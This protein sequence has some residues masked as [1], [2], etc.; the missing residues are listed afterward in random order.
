[1]EI[2]NK[3]SEDFLEYANAVITSRAIPKVQDNLKPVHRRVLYSMAIKKLWS[4]KSMLKCANVV[5]QVMVYH[6]HGDSAIYDSLIRLSQDWKM[7]YP[8]VEVGGNNGS[9]LGDP[10]AAS[11][12][13]ECRLSKIGELMLE[14]LSPTVVPFK[15]NYD[16]TTTEPTMLPSKF[17]N[18][19]CNGN[20]G[21]A[22][23]L[24]S[25]LVPHNLTE[26]VSAILAYIN[27]NKIGI[28]EL[29]EYIP[30]PDFPTGGVIIDSEKLVDIYTFGSGAI[31]L[32][33]KYE[34]EKIGTKQAIHFT[35][36]PYLIDVEEGVVKKIKKLVNEDGFDLIEGYEN[37]TN[38]NGISLRV[39]LKKGA[40]VYKVLDALWKNT[41]LQTSQRISN[42]VIYNGVPRVLNLKEMIVHYINYRHE[43]I[44]NIAK[45]ELIKVKNKIIVSQ[46]LIKA[47]KVIDDIIKIIRASNDKASA[48]LS[49]IKKYGFIEMQ[50][51]AILDMK[52]SKLSKLD[53]EEI[54]A[55]LLLLQKKEKEL[56]KIT[57][58][59]KYRNE[60]I[61]KELNQMKAD[62]GD[63]RRTKLSNTSIAVTK[64]ATEPVNMI[65]FENGKVFTSQ[66][67]ISKMP[68]GTRSSVLNDAA[69]RS[70]VHAK[71]IDI[72]S[73]FSSDGV[74]TKHKILNL[75]VDELE[76][77][78]STIDVVAAFDIENSK[79]EMVV[80][81]T[82]EGTV[83]MTT[84]D[85]Y[86]KVK[87]T[88][89]AIKLREGDR[90]IYV[91]LVNK[92]DVLYILGE[93]GKLV[94]FSISDITSTSRLTIGTKG[95]NDKAI[96]ALA[97]G[98][99]NKIFSINNSNQAKL[100]N[101]D[102]FN[103]TAKGSNGQVITENTTVILDGDKDYILIYDNKKNSLV[104]IKNLAVKSKSSIGAKIINGDI[105]SI[106]N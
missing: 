32:Q 67:D 28:E 18:I 103:L 85:E 68:F 74:I 7:R 49:I 102:D 71:P 24:S 73:T 91:G 93:K 53:N 99:N 96:C 16:E 95:I 51:E 47:I 17:P 89:K 90:L 4:N 62:F 10:A 100:T 14:D 80:F 42:T 39:F 1:M 92:N 9:V 11:R 64:L 101:A 20:A 5:G 50:A 98:P 40:N 25:S 105:I 56:V 63:A 87:T 70:I 82:Q 33:A 76:T 104:S 12:Y 58:N 38:R 59:E 75:T 31:T 79:K 72:L 19:I 94:K 2:N 27:N 13:T 34:I 60:I 86:S 41:R 29:M 55:D 37:N 52:L 81:V 43:I 44:T 3:I 77:L 6:P 45:E 66:N 83:K 57:T 23:G 21:I 8:L 78:D 97:C 69:I 65:I 106:V 54:E 84:I 88:T 36:I 61:I 35:E 22:V 48:K 26:A 15:S 30:G 46:G